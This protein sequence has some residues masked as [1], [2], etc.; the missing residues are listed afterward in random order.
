MSDI[1]TCNP[2]LRIPLSLIID[3][4][5]PVIN[6]AYYWIQQR[7]DWRIQHRPNT[8]PRGWEV[9]YN[10]LSSMPNIIPA[11]FT[12]KWGEWCGEQGIKGKFS[13]VPFPAGI[14]RVDQGFKGFPESELEKWLQ[15]AK[16][17]IWN[18]F[19]L[20]PEMLTH[21][22]VVDL[23]TWQLTEAW[24]QGEWVDPP[25]DKLTEYIVAAMQLLKNVGIPCEGVTSPGAFGKQ[26][27]E[28]YSRAILD[29]ALHV[30]NNPRPFYFL[31]LIH[32][33]LPD[34]PIWQIDKDKG[35]AIASIV[36][37]AGDWF[38]ATGY[39]TADADL[40]ITEDLESGRLPAVLA[41]ERPCVL[42]GHWP[43]FYVNDEIGFQVLKIVKQRLDA[44]D[45]DGT[46]TIWMK[47]SEIGHYW[48]ARR[49]SNIQP[50]PN[51]RQAEQIIQIETQFPTTNFTL[52]TDT[53]ANRIQVNGLDLKQVQ[54]RRNFRSG[55]YLT[56]AGKTYLA[57]ELDQGQT[58]IFL[59]Q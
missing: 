26:K 54:S 45:P 21:T 4:S 41:A 44:Y 42:V 1:K 6:K 37:C 20:T 39:D 56:E 46:K 33:Q 19:D 32:D 8:Q 43:C 47:N 22:R 27:E 48:M 50:V 5:C 29:A 49:L 31:W 9:H 36:R 12:A 18:N 2:L 58:T 10:K 13:I 34:V 38:G 40:F 53:V 30:N 14:G 52:S 57:F 55:T 7:H 11:D 23:D 51:D 35:Q 3:D 28:A 16:E 17:V 15:V 25:V 59:L 24:E